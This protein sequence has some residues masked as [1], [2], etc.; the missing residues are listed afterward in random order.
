MASTKR[1]AKKKEKTAMRGKLYL[2]SLW[3][4][5]EALSI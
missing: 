1:V 2:C 3:P 5:P 4:F